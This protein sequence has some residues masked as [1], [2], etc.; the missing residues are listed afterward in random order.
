ME[1][2]LLK[3]INIPTPVEIAISATLK[4]ALKSK[5]VAA[6]NRQPVRRVPFQM[7]IKHINY[8]TVKISAIRLF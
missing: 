2:F 5:I 1:R 4:M 7:E 8:F 6:P 3:N